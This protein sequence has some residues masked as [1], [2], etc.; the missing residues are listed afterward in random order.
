MRRIDNIIIAVGGVGYR[1]NCSQRGLSSKCFIKINNKTLLD[2]ILEIIESLELESKITFVVTNKEQELNCYQCAQGYNINFSI[3]Y[4][5]F[6]DV[7]YTLGNKGNILLIYGDSFFVDV[8]LIGKMLQLFL[9]SNKSVYLLIHTDNGI[10]NVCFEVDKKSYMIRRIYS[11]KQSFEAS[12]VFIFTEEDC[13]YI[14]ENIMR[15]GKYK[16][17][18]NHLMKNRKSLAVYGACININEDADLKLAEKIEYEKNNS[19]DY[20]CKY[21]VNGR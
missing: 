15:F 3:E 1:L 18:Y 7:F 16:L 12:Q 5:T 8:N 17:I 6:N 13:K 2:R 9:Q 11:G 21:F 19:K 20:E 14:N 10:D 4:N